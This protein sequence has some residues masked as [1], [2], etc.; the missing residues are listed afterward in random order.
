M[1]SGRH[2]T[3]YARLLVV[4]HGET[5]ENAIGVFQG[6]GGRG[7]NEVGRAQAER[8]AERLASIPIDRFYASDLQRARETAEILARGADVAHD[9]ALREVDVGDWTGL[10]YEEVEERFPEEFAAW[11]DGLD[12]RRGGGETYAELAARVRGALEVIADRHPGE[13]VCVVSHGAAIKSVI[14]SL[15][16]LHDPGRRALVAMANTSVTVLERAPFGFKVLV[17]NDTSHLGD[18]LGPLAARHRA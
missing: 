9:R 5:A 11:R 6:Q 13:L 3:R 1:T 2:D 7:L 18:P 15:L 4:R 17:F 14:A 10:A 8:L 12:V 16:E